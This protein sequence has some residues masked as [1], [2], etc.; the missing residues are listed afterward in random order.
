MNNRNSGNALVG[1]KDEFSIGLQEID[2][3]H[4]ALFELINRLW[5]AIVKQASTEEILKIVMDLERYTLSHF[6]A[7]E[8]FMRVSEYPGFP[9]HKKEHE[10]FV[11]RI[12]KE[13][14][15][16]TGGKTISL[17]LIQFLKD[18]LINHILVSDKDYAGF[19]A[20][21][22]ERGGLGHFFKRFFS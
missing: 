21:K 14:Q 8:T 20:R 6:T 10:E 9:Q 7:E 11:A 1:W 18:W 16:V 22:N 4:Q 5:T 17:D 12:A 13:R 3:Q 19:H 2:E 15:S